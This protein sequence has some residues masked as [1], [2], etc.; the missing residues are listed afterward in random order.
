MT[1][2]TIAAVTALDRPSASS[3]PPKR[4]YS[5]PG[6]RNA[7]MIRSADPSSLRS[8]PSPATAHLVGVMFSVVRT[9]HVE[10]FTHAAAA[11]AATA[12]AT[13]ATAATAVYNYVAK[14]ETKIE[15]V[16]FSG[17]RDH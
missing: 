14:K 10:R 5:I 1:P 17:R 8:M 4:P 15:G 6:A 13:A 2:V 3:S 7:P 9:C 12:A 16:V 11:T